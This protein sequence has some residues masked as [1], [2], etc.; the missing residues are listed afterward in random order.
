M[1]KGWA[2]GATAFMSFLKTTVC[3]SLSAGSYLVNSIFNVPTLMTVHLHV[4]V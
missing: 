2:L 1:R 4:S 3:S